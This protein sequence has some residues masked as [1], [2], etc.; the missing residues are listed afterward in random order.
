MGAQGAPAARFAPAVVTVASEK[1]QLELG[2]P[3]LGTEGP[4]AGAG[5]PAGVCE[6]G[7]AEVVA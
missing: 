4:W 7:A 6:V 5:T 1:R 3:R 2:T